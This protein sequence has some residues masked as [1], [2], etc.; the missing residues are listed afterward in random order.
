MLPD[1]FYHK[2]TPPYGHFKIPFQFPESNTYQFSCVLKMKN[3]NFLTF[4]RFIS[5]S[6]N[7]PQDN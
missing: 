2:K 5:L 7:T 6:Y 1:E 3:N 4:G